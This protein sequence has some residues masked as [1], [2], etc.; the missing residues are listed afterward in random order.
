MRT[1]KSFLSILLFFLI[2]ISLFSCK[3]SQ[4]QQESISTNITTTTAASITESEVTD[5][6]ISYTFNKENNILT[7]DGSK[8]HILTRDGYTKML[9]DMSHSNHTA[10]TVII[11]EGIKEI[12]SDVFYG[13]KN[14]KSIS[15]PASLSAIG[16]HALFGCDKLVNITVSA[17]NQHF[18]T[19]E[20]GV[21][22]SKDMTNLIVYP[23]ALPNKEYTIPKTVTSICS[24]AFYICPNLTALHLSPNLSGEFTHWFYCCDNLEKITL[25]E[26]SL[27]YYCDEQGLICKKDTKEIV[28]VPAEIRTLEFPENADS[29]FYD[30]MINNE[31]I[32]E[33]VLTDTTVNI[34]EYLFQFPNLKKLTINGSN[35]NYFCIDGVLYS[36]DKTT[37]LWYPPMKDGKAFNVPNTVERVNFIRGKQLEKIIFSDSVKVID[38]SAFYGCESLEYVYIG[39]GLKKFDYNDE[40]SSEHEN[41]FSLCKNLQKITVDSGNKNFA[42]DKYG[43]LCTADMKNIITLPANSNTE[44]YVINDSVTCIL[45]CFKNCVNLKKLHIG[46]SVEYVNVGVADTE[47]IVGFAGCI[48]LEEI[49]V[50]EK[51]ENY[52]S[53]DGVLYS[54]DKSELCLYPAN[55]PGEEFIIPDSVE[56]VGDFAFLGNRTLKRIYAGNYTKSNLIFNFTDYQKGFQLPIDIYF[57]C[58]KDDFPY[59][60]LKDN[61]KIHFE[62]KGLPKN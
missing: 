14:I 1:A 10:E 30:A 58:K 44:K 57:S 35:P 48:S 51:N 49:T 28:F 26:N 56:Q 47:T 31:L 62:A 43:A 8:T 7:I 29:F 61:S 37:L 12:E 5:E 36:K 20:T 24:N 45:S 59:D 23:S 38:N 55:K 21:L 52:I 11:T 32:T 46:S 18:T 33:I 40:F 2:I 41:I 16:R 9:S 19:D 34:E 4:P 39:K 53:V 15:L 22:F 50:S 27:N 13:N 42:T 3:K 17:Q 25:P 6:Q 54:K 60:Y